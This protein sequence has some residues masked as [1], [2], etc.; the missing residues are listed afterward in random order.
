MGEDING[1]GR[2]Q[3]NVINN[4]LHSLCSCPKVCSWE[5]TVDFDWIVNLPF[6]YC[7]TAGKYSGDIHRESVKLCLSP[8]Q[9][10]GLNLGILKRERRCLSFCAKDFAQHRLRFHLMS[11]TLQDNSGELFLYHPT[12]KGDFKGFFNFHIAVLM[13]TSRRCSLFYF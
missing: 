3:M 4:F 12:I 5:C 8:S 1:R 7:A 11:L 9:V 2:T 13:I 6:V 10:Q